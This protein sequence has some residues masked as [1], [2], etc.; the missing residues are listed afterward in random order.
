M[1]AK[2]LVFRISMFHHLSNWSN[3]I[4]VHFYLK[5]IASFSFLLSL[6]LVFKCF[7]FFVFGF[8][9]LFVCDYFFYFFLLWNLADESWIFIGWSFKSHSLSEIRDFLWVTPKNTWENIQHYTYTQ[10]PVKDH[11]LY[12]SFCIQQWALLIH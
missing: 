3:L 8:S 2:Y 9:C 1:K 11:R 5:V 12:Y 7:G 6:I 4:D 10:N